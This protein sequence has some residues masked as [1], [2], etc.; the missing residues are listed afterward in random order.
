MEESVK[1]WFEG[2]D[3]P[4][5][6]YELLGTPRLEPDREELLQAVRNATRVLLLYHVGTGREHL[7]RR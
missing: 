7:L 6:L 5:D 1:R 4:G 3:M 2:D